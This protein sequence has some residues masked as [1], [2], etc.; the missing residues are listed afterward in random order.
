MW[1]EL[2]KQTTQDGSICLNPN[3][4]RDNKRATQRSPLSALRY[5]YLNTY[6][7]H[8]QTERPNLL[9]TT[10]FLFFL[11]FRSSRYHMLRV[12]SAFVY[13]RIF[14]HFSAKKLKVRYIW[15]TS[16]DYI[17]IYHTKYEPIHHI[18]IRF[19]IKPNVLRRDIPEIRV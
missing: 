12:S 3:S 4:P 8:T 1:W 14:M 16:F 7:R 11:P 18:A 17:L 15:R 6:T 9:F 13:V 2:A 19:V 10:K 5:T